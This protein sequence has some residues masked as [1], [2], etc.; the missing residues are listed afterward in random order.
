MADY[1]LVLDAAA[2]EGRVRPALA[3]S[4]RRRSF[5]PCRGLCADLLPAARAYAR[6]YHTG[7][8]PSLV[9]RVVGGLPFDRAFWRALAGEVLLFSAADIPE[10]Q[11]C[12]DTLCCLLAPSHCNIDVQERM[13]LAPIQ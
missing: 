6:R 4:W 1:F 10:F 11:T 2:F 9:E 3:E 5:D 13:R 12:P 7:T 8:E